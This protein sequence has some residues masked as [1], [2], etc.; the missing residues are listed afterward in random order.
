MNLP[1]RSETN[2]ALTGFM[3]V[4]KSAVGQRLSRRLRMKFVDLDRAIEKQERMRVEAIFQR[5]G[6]PY[7]RR[8]EKRVLKSVL[9]HDGQV[10]A[11]GGGVVLD[12]ENFRLLKE[13][14]FLVWLTAPVKVLLKRAGTG[15]ERPLLAGTDLRQRVEELLER[16]EP[17]YA[18]S[19]ASID[20]AFLSVDEVVEEIIKAIQTRT[21]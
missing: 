10:I 16:R 11:T 20:T 3:A 7:F 2:I 9:K 21:E 8:V 1:A 12:E 13:R 19:D 15:K 17:R 4:G 14:T 5:K 18:Q 6:E